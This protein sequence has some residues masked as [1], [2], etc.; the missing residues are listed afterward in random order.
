[1]YSRKSAAWRIGAVM[2]T[3]YTVLWRKSEPPMT[4]FLAAQLATS[5]Y[6]DI[7]RARQDFGY[8]PTISTEEGMKRLAEDLAARGT[9]NG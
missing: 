1:M 8:R 5:H 2:E 3:A 9:R 6:F 4:R 7:S